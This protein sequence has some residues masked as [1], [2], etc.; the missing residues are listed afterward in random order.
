MRRRRGRRVRVLSVL[1]AGCLALAIGATLHATGA[2]HRIELLTVDLRF[3]ARGAQPPPPDVV[4]VGIDDR[5]FSEFTF[6]PY[7]LPRGFHA[8]VIR[9]LVQSG[10]RVIAYD[11]QFT[12][13]SASAAADNALVD[14]VARARGRIVLATTETDGKG[15]TRVLGGDDLLR[16]IGARAGNAVIPADANG[17]IRQM[18]REVDELHS[19]PVAVAELA[20]RSAVPRTEF[21][22]NQAWIDFHGPP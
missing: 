22:G 21:D 4:I 2:L 3:D 9:R 8:R 7:P 12:E 20:T 13:P 6:V 18:P 15:G 14:A 16:E 10:A 5:T 1:L 17:V 19:F 11:I